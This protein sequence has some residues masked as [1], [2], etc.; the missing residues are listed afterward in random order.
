MSILGLH[1]T[2][3]ENIPESTLEQGIMIL[4]RISVSVVV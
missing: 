1:G 4:G 2:T 3:L